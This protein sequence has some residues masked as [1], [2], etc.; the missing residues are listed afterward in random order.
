MQVGQLVM[1]GNGAVHMIDEDHVRLAGLDAGGQDPDPEVARRH[2]AL[3]GPVLRADQGPFF[4]L[5]D[6]AHE[7][8]GEQNAV[9]Q[10]ERLAVRVAAG[11]PAQLDELLHFRMIDGNVDGGAA[12]AQRPL[13]N[14]QGERIHDADE[15]HDARRLAVVADAL[16][17]RAQ[18]APIAADA[19]AARGEPDILVPQ[20]D[21]A[22]QA[23]RS[24]VEEAGNGQAAR[25]AAVR[26]DRR[27]RHEPQIAHIV[28]EP[29]GMRRIVGE[30]HRDAGKQVLIAF[31]RHQIAVGKGLFAEFR[32]VFVAIAVDL[33]PDPAW[34]LRDIQ[35][36]LMGFLIVKH[37]F[38]RFQRDV[39]RLRS[40]VIHKHLIPR[41]SVGSVHHSPSCPQLWKEQNVYKPQ[42]IVAGWL[43]S[44]KCAITVP[45]LSSKKRLTNAPHCTRVPCSEGT[46]ARESLGNRSVRADRN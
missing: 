22:A 21:D 12:A 44:T 5:F 14:G 13:R 1:L 25:R 16:A 28:V 3:D 10:V 34:I 26:Q 4:V 33:D 24:L 18:I 35:H 46:Y 38:R 19:A 40:H 2:L 23:V 29:L 41:E 17:D 27:R 32:Q 42:Y 15:G 7:G 30:M 36:A 11:G 39:M 45:R 31:A 43:K 6:R 37:R 20:I 9:M 8:I